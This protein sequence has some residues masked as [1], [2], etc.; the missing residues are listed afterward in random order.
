[1]TDFKKVVQDGK[2]GWERFLRKIPGYKG[3]AQKE[4]R[5]EAD[6]LLR[7]KVAADLDEQRRRLNEQQMA[8]VNSGQIMLT[9]DLDR[10]ISKLQT[11]TD[12]IKT[13]SYGY[14]GLFDAVKV[15]EDQLDAL[16]AFD[17]GLLQG[18]ADIAA[19]IDKVA[20][21]IS[22]SAEVGPAISALVQT[23]AKY[24]DLFSKRQ[25]AIVNAGQSL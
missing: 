15:K 24:N 18:V 12:R 20:A 7:L 11:L 23:V 9:D 19:G 1:M 22:Q 16:Y 8:L 10:A 25:E 2:G 3:Y 17:A 14:A 5:R 4:D 21:A 13:A 6:K